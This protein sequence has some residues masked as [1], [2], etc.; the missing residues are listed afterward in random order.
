LW[1]A[2][3]DSNQLQTA[4]L[5]IA[6]NARDAMPNGGELTIR[7]RNVCFAAG[8]VPFADIAAGDYVAIEIADTGVGMSA[9]IA[10]RVFEP[11]F[12]TKEHGKG[13]GLG[14][15]MVYGFVKQSGGLITV[16]SEP[17]K[18]T[19]FTLYFQRAR[20]PVNGDATLSDTPLT[21]HTSTELTSGR[22]R[23][24][25]AVDDNVE[26]L[27]SASAQLEALGYR[28]LSANSPEAAL[29]ILSGPEP[30]DLLFTDVV[31]PGGL[32]GKRLAVEACRLRPELKVLFTSGFPNA[33][34]FQNLQT[35]SDDALL[36]KPYRLQELGQALHA[37]LDRDSVRAA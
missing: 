24:V 20:E 16:S 11:F 37:V 14:L 19:T 29:I 7:T 31:M 1:H 34:E 3:T 2:R 21:P 27:A 25:L 36:A 35:A 15:S 22:R 13:T 6:F 30:V 5:N 10:N 17:A 8:E 26:V 28:V 9:D 4:I 32:N 12:T 33:P 23:V 18:G